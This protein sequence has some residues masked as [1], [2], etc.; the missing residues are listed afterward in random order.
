MSEYS[1][2]VVLASAGTGKT[3]SLTNQ[4]LRLLFLNEDPGKILATTFT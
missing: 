2:K 3:Y 1:N 4:Y